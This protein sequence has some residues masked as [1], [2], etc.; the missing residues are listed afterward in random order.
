MQFSNA[1]QTKRFFSA[2]KTPFYH[3]FSRKNINICLGIDYLDQGVL[4]G[5]I[6]FF[7][8]PFKM[9]SPCLYNI[10]KLR[11]CRLPYRQSIVNL[12]ASRIWKTQLLM[13]SLFYINCGSQYMQTSQ[14]V[15]FQNKSKSSLGGIMTV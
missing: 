6:I 3:P 5:Q 15:V 14:K 1:S 7:I 8:F 10:Q 9:E 2:Q 4:M 13:Y 11:K 12:S